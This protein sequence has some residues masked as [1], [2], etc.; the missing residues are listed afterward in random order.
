MRRG[1]RR[2]SPAGWRSRA[3]A[4]R[5]YVC[6]NLSNRLLE[7]DAADRRGA[8]A[9]RRRRRAVRCRARRRQGL[10]QQLGRPPAR[11]R[12]SDRTGRSRHARCASIR[13]RHIASEGSVSVVDLAAGEVR[14][15]MLTGLARQRPG[16]VAR[17]PLRRLRQRRQRPSER[18]RHADG[19]SRRQRFG[20][21]RSRPTCS[22]RR[23]TRWRSTPSGERL[24]VANGTQNAIAVIRVRCRRA[25]A[26]RSSLGLIPV[27]W[28][29]G[30]VVVDARAQVDRRRQHQG[31]AEAAGA[32]PTTRGAQGL[33]LASVFRLGVARADSAGR[34]AAAALG[35]S[36]RP[37]CAAADRRRPCCRR[38]RISRRGQCPSASASRA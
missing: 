12:R 3:T 11:P 5:L 28:Y 15:E 22:A 1:G 9:V 8:A 25:E 16:G 14:R 36:L 31:A 27:G 4:S 35:A 29:P 26:S 10:R 37:T 19:R 38:A 18:H 30:A 20:R 17:R 7:L 2:K 23:R 6:G 34:G 24:Y 13:V 21:S 32:S 33:Q